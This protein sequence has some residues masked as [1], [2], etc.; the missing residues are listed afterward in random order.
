MVFLVRV[1]A[2]LLWWEPVISICDHLL[3]FQNFPQNINIFVQK[4]INKKIS[5]MTQHCYFSFIRFSRSVWMMED[6]GR[7]RIRWKGCRSRIGWEEGSRKSD[8]TRTIRIRIVVQR[9]RIP[10]STGTI[11]TR[12]VVF[13]MIRFAISISVVGSEKRRV[14]TTSTTIS[15]RSEPIPKCFE[16]LS[17]RTE[18]RRNRTGAG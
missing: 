16:T 11:R 3:R 15:S 1:E 7:I 18:F 2:K 8:R 13:Q 6:L 12:V 5:K 14:A 9:I 4:I 10:I 17:I